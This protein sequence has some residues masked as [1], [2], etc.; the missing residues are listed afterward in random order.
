MHIY[1]G[2]LA[3]T[4]H[5]REVLAV[6][7][8]AAAIGTAVGLRKLD[9]ERI[10]RAAVLSS[11]FFVIS[12]IHVPLPATTEHLTLIGL[13]GLVLGWAA[14]PAVLIALLLQ[15]VFF[16]HGGLTSLG[17]N[18]LI[19]A[20]PA[21]ICHYL[22]R[23]A[24]RSRSEAAVFR[25]GFMVGVTATLLGASLAVGSLLAA[26]RQFQMAGQILAAAHLPLAVVE[27]LVTA[28]VVVL[29]R[30]VRPELLDAPLLVPD[31]KEPSHG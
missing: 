7:A 1:E 3:G 15:A 29:L 24:V 20:L 10:P 14:F 11:A 22:F 23:R 16:S 28:A 27:G 12:M 9:F 26:G 5:G 17:V 4:P 6:G 30:K 31:H 2:I 13:M 21:V 18:T 19:M 8:A 25:I